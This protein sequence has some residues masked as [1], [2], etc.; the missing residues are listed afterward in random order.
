MKKIDIKIP[1]YAKEVLRRLEAAGFEAWCVGGCVRDA[2]QGV[3]PH[4]W[5]ICTNAL[6]NQTIK[7]F[8][9]YSVIPTGI[10][11]G[12][13]T[14]LIEKNPIEITTY[15]TDGG[16]SDHRRPDNV[17]FV[18]DVKHDLERRDFTMNAIC[19]NL[20][21]ELYDPFDGQ[22]DIKRKIIRCVGDPKKRFDEDAL[23]I[24]RAIRFASKTGFEIEK[25]TAGAAFQMRSLLENVSAE[26]LY[27][28]FKAL[29]VGR[30]VTKVLLEYK[31]II[32]QIVPEITPCFGFKQNN[33]HHCYDVWEHIARSVS[34]SR[35][36]P[37]IRLVMV[38]HDIGKPDMFFE[39][40]KGVSHFKLHQL[41]SAEYAGVILKRFNCDNYTRKRVC[42]LIKEHDN[43]IGIGRKSVK[44]FISKYDYDF[45]MDYLEV[46][47]A[48]TLAQSDFKR[49]QKLKEL[50][51]LALIAI[52]VKE[53]NDCLK[54]NDLAV[55]GNEMIAL[56]LK[57]SQIGD[58][59]K[60]LL[61]EVVEERLSNE[62]NKLIDAAER[63]MNN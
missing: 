12:T 20:K 61:E 51:D 11:H 4:D 38:F 63:K 17:S 28:E 54:L 50:D 56:G 14:V 34:F 2:L 30:N 52:D 62:A 37:L 47:R 5:D 40:E 26:R 44:K 1:E 16:Y 60:F 25:E 15:R 13:V 18:R 29:L 9:G 6:P 35:P 21:G 46:R 57:G 42:A 49:E 53:E 39:D 27:S 22:D 3:A 23:R 59:L 58:M 8:K 36:E 55:G 31:E 45:F 7:A 32:A 10:K 19:L 24:L 41:K 43:R 33:P 48:D